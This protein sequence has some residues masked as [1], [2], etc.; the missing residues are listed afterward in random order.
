[1]GRERL[2]IG[3]E[4]LS[5]QRIPNSNGV[6]DPKI[7]IGRCCC[8]CVL[9]FLQGKWAGK[10]GQ[11]KMGRETLKIGKDCRKVCAPGF[12]S[13]VGEGVLQFA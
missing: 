4:S 6:L 3:A 8:A 11:G 5:G 10:D 12:L 9:G 13:Q 7:K 1:V 2:K